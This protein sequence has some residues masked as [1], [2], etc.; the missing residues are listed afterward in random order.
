MGF[1]K[2]TGVS[3]EFSMS[4]LTDIIF[5]LL[6]FFMLTSSLVSPT[7]VNLKLPN[8]SKNS[9]SKSTHSPIKLSI[10]KKKQ[11]NLNGKRIAED[12][13]LQEL[14]SAIKKDGRKSS[15]ITIILNIHEKVDAQTLVTMVDMMNNFGVK[16]ILATKLN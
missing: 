5:L 1:K 9:T 8:S 3:A 12:K 15:D 11:F 14:G 13:V 2:R 16:M 4:S 10:N 6:I 7:A